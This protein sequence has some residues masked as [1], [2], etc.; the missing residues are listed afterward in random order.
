MR[1]LVTGGAGFIG[2]YTVDRLLQLGHEARVLDNLDGQVHASGR[3][4]SYFNKEAE[5]IKGDVRDYNTVVRA[6]KGPDAIFHLAACVGVGQSQYLI[7]KYTDVAIG[8]TA[9]LLDALVNTKN[10]V[11]KVVVAAS[12]SSYGEGLYKCAECGEVRPGPRPEKDLK[13]KKWEFR[14]P[15]CGRDLKPVPIDEKQKQRCNSIYAITKRTQEEMVL[16]IAATY[17][18]PSVALRYFNVYGPRQALSN[19]YTGVCA[20][21]L[22]RIKNNHPPVVY[23][24]GLQTR[25]FISVHDI[26]DANM[27]ALNKK[28]ADYRS[29]NVGTGTGLPIKKIAEVL[30]GLYKKPLEPA[31]SNKYRKGDIRHCIADITNIRKA[32]GFRPKVDFKDGMRELIEWSKTVSAVDSFEKA[33]VELKRKGLI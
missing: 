16:N 17:K 33:R 23:E 32:L 7:K 18:I 10:R 1:I 2:S 9:N 8:G 31:I 5:F 25:D 24:D 21:F 6:I 29:F 22:S 26:V 12:M 20:I 19:P 4:P 11:R 3:L 28:A 27:L 14:C 30:I 13:A 15:A